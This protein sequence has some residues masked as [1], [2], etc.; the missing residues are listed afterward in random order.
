MNS[1]AK[2]VEGDYLEGASSDEEVDACKN[3]LDEHA[4]LETNDSDSE[5]KDKTKG[6]PEDDDAPMK[7][8]DPKTKEREWANCL[9]CRLRPFHW[10]WFS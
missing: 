2:D 3:D 1:F 6:K 8:D 4:H 10:C 5:T 9:V 7:Q